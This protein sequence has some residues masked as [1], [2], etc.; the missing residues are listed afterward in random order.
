MS[1]PRHPLIRQFH[2]ARN[3]WRFRGLV[4]ALTA[5]NLRVKYKGSALGF[6]WVLISPLAT[7]AVL[8]TV[9]TYVLRVDVERFWAFLLSGYFVWRFVL[10]TLTSATYVLAS[11]G[12]LSRAA[13]FPKDAPIIAAALSRLVEFGLELTWVLVAL[14]IFHHG[15]VPVSFVLLPWLIL[16]QVLMALGL[17]FPVATLSA[18]FR[19]VQHAVPVVLTALFYLSP[20]FYPIALVPD[21]LRPVFMANPLAGLLTLYQSAVYEGQMPTTGL[22][23]T[24]SAVAAGLFIVGYG[25]FH[26]YAR[27]FAEIV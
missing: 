21:T 7:V 19:D 12:P 9:F 25:I 10:Q 5:R 15:S 6:V 14:V 17:A 26:R 20:V 2:A 11:H 8:A 27:L 23:L 13:A 16:I 1:P 18:F 4:R 3:L 24:V 22:L